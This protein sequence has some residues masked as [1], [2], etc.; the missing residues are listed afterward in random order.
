MKKQPQFL[1]KDV[2]SDLIILV[3]IFSLE[4]K[5]IYN[6]E[7]TNIAN[8]ISLFE[9]YNKIYISDTTI[10][11]LL[12]IDII[13]LIN[14]TLYFNKNQKISFDNLYKEKSLY[15]PKKKKTII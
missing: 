5:L 4:N 10:S 6:K 15:Q 2:E 11:L 13:I 14:I 12:F 1:N 3:F 9:L 7:I 8:M